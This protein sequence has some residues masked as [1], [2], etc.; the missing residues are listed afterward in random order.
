MHDGSRTLAGQMAD[1]LLWTDVHFRI[2]QVSAVKLHPQGSESMI[3]VT[4]NPIFSRQCVCHPAILFKFLAVAE[5]GLKL[6]EGKRCN[7]HSLRRDT[8]RLQAA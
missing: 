6:T 4:L 1:L 3:A 5:V 7:M 8:D 2:V